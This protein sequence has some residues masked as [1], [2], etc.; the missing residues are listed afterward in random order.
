MLISHVLI[1]TGHLRVN[2]WVDLLSLAFLPACFYFG[3]TW[4]VPG[5]AWAWLLGFPLIVVLKVVLVSRILDLPPTAYL[6]ALGPALIACL[7]MSS[8]VLLVGAS[9]PTSWPPPAKLV[10]QASFGAITYIVVLL[11]VFHHRV[12]TIYEAIRAGTRS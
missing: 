4:G 6:S 2:M 3:L 12:A 10:L 9:L 7:A 8:V 5:V 1:W 11:G